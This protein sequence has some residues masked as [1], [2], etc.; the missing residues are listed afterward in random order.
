MPGRSEL[1]LMQDQ[2]PLGVPDGIERG[3]SLGLA[4][5]LGAA[6]GVV[7]LLLLVGEDQGR[8][9]IDAGDGAGGILVAAVDV[10]AEPGIAAAPVDADHAMLVHYG[11]VALDLAFAAANTVGQGSIGDPQDRQLI[12]AAARQQPQKK[13]ERFDGGAA[14]G[15]ATGGGVENGAGLLDA[16]DGGGEAAIG[17]GTGHGLGLP[18]I[19]AGDAAPG[20]VGGGRVRRRPAAWVAGFVLVACSRSHLLGVR[21]SS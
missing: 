19:A 18:G 5:L 13:L 10:E 1:L 2:R 7:E 6:N 20:G 11:E 9:E 8:A 3:L 21:S 14:E 17:V 4:T 12:P 15:A 16:G